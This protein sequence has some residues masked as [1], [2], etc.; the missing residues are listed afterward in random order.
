MAG[1]ELA[2]ENVAAGQD[3]QFEAIRSGAQ[4]LLRTYQERLRI[5]TAIVMAIDQFDTV[6]ALVRA[7]DSAAAA[8]L[9]LMRVLEVDEQQAA[10]VADMQVRRL[11]QREHRQLTADCAE[12]VSHVADL[13]SLLSS[14]D[15]MRDLAGTEKGEYLARQIR[16]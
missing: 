5:L 11:A 2:R 12:M 9:E 4:Y 7:S 1:D 16:Q 15:R 3:G 10:A 13:E 6:T 8:R 14:P